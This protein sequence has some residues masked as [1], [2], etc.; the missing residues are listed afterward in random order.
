MKVTKVCL[1]QNQLSEVESAIPTC[2]PCQA[3]G[4]HR[5]HEPL[6]MSKL[7]KCPWLNLSIAF[8]GLFPSGDSLLVITYEYSCYLVVEIVHNTSI[9]D[10][11]LIFDKV[12][13]LFEYLSVIKTD[14]GPQFRSSLW[15]SF[16]ESCRIKH[17]LI[18]PLWP[19]A[20]TQAESFNK[21][22]MKAVRSAHVQRK[23]WK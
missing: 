16:M 22:M 6:N 13:A 11:I 14:N 15:K 12:F 23:S 9:E 17:C 2:L 1:R 19:K 8:C 20:N 18:T 3:N 4:N 7:L 5:D 21:P 10:I